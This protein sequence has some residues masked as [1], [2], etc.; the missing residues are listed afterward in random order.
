MITGAIF[1]ALIFGGIALVF[2]STIADN[3]W[4][5][6]L[7]TVGAVMA[8]AGLIGGLSALPE[9]TN[10]PCPE[11]TVKADPNNDLYTGCIPVE[12]AKKQVETND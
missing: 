7:P 4:E 11:N 1:G 8:G 2:A 10:E 5:A 12:V 6:A 9:H 3:F